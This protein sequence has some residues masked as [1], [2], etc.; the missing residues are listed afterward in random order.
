MSSSI[1]DQISINDDVDRLICELSILD[2]KGDI[3]QIIHPNF[4]PS[5]IY[6]GTSI[7]FVI[8]A[9]CEVIADV[10]IIGLSLE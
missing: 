1:D 9:Y 4:K 2:A 3:I 6:I 10:Q 7:T 8:T 5:E